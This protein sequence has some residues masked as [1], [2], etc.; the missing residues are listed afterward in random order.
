MTVSHN[1]RIHLFFALGSWH[2]CPKP[3][4]FTKWWGCLLPLPKLLK[5]MPV[6]WLSLCYKYPKAGWSQGRLPLNW[7]CQPHSLDLEIAGHRPWYSEIWVS[8][9][10][11]WGCWNGFGRELKRAWLLPQ[12]HLGVYCCFIWLFPVLSFLN[13]Q[14]SYKTDD[15]L[16]IISRVSSSSVAPIALRERV[17]GTPA[18]QLVRWQMVCQVGTAPWQKA[19]FLRGLGG[20]VNAF[21]GNSDWHL[22]NWWVGCWCGSEYLHC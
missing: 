4:E 11:W 13:K 8:S 3:L 7:K 19:L 10:G 12:I 21:V 14:A 6:S 22:E 18:M 15:A 2:S 17:S 20:R 5:L 9:L 16:V 1:T